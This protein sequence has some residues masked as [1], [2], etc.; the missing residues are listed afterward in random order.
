MKD[1][2]KET[3]KEEIQARETEAQ[4]KPH[5]EDSADTETNRGEPS[6][7][8]Q[9]E[10]YKNKSQEYYDRL[11]RLQADFDNYRKRVAREKDEMYSYIAGDILLELLGVLD[12]ME[13]ASLSAADNGSS[14]GSASMK[15]GIDMV[16]KQLIDILSKHGVE[17]IPAQG[18]KFDPNLHHAVMQVDDKEQ[19]EGTILEVLQKGYRIKSRVLRPSIVKVAL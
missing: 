11:L 5:E 4:E 13:R 6:R 10:E 15:E 17:E 2:K 18:E 7:D 8:Q 14:N 3:I 9:L 1:K 19:Q 12:N 16:I